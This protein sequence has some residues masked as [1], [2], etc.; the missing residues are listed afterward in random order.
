MI[1][2][3]S[4]T[5]DRWQPATWDEMVGNATLKEVLQNLVYRVRVLGKTDTF[6]AFA[7][8]PSRGGKTSTIQFAIKCL[9]CSD[10]DLNS[11]NPCH[12]C[13]YCR[14]DVEL[15]GT[16]GWHEWVELLHGSKAIPFIYIPV[17]CT[18][19]TE[20]ELESILFSLR[21]NAE[22]LQIVYWDEIHRLAR[23]R[24]DERLLVA[25][26]K[27]KAIW[28]ASSAIVGEL[29]QMF[30]NRFDERIKVQLPEVNELA[31]FL[32]NRCEEWDIRCAGDPC[33]TLTRL[34][35]RANQVPGL[36]LQVLRR[37]YGSRE[38]ILTMS[39]VENFEFILDDAILE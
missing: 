21:G 36:A 10:L 35:E 37:A 20:G 2:I 34:A 3:P 19:L 33:K 18:R 39:T 23:R 16:N 25:M 11:L 31:I 7:Y 15:H 32:A 14:E 28:L 5:I 17:D 1:V 38:R 24:M 27:Y 4:R 22:Q 8:G 29:D 30:L 12:Q 6:R 13:H 9:L 26:D